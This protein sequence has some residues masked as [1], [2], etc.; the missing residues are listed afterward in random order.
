MMTMTMMTEMMIIMIYF[1]IV[2]KSICC[3][4]FVYKIK[5]S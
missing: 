1:Y 5:C 2:Y 3:L 4:V